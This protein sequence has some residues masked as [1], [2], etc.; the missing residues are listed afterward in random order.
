MLINPRQLTNLPDIT[1]AR[2]KMQEINFGAT[3]DT[4]QMSVAAQKLSKID[5]TLRDFSSSIPLNK[6]HDKFFDAEDHLRDAISAH[7]RGNYTEALQH[8]R[9]AQQAIKDGD[10]AMY[11]KKEKKTPALVSGLANVHASFDDYYRTVL[12]AQFSIRTLNNT[13]KYTVSVDPD[14]IAKNNPQY[15][16]KRAENQLALQ[17]RKAL[18]G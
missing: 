18:R 17:R 10:R 7:S 3:K 8:A 9:N 15:A 11:V 5:D 2:Q 12:P 1:T 4:D 14:Y 13:G 6:F 16:K